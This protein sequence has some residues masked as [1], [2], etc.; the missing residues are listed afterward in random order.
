DASAGGQGATAAG[1]AAV[2]RDDGYWLLLPL[3]L[4]GLFAFQRGGGVGAL[5]LCACLPWHQARAADGGTL[6]RRADQV[7]H[8][9]MR[10]G[11]DAYRRK[12]YAEAADAWQALPGAEAAYN[13]GNALARAGRYEDAI[14]A[15]DEA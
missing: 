2:W 15:Y 13:S 3:M 14:K 7:R 12:D 10:E 11:A 5:L 4:L 8:E 1:K 6:W 9:R